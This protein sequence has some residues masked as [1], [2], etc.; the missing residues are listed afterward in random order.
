MGQRIHPVSFDHL[1]NL[2][3]VMGVQLLT[4]KQFGKFEIRDLIGHGAMGAVYLAEQINLNRRPVALKVLTPSN[5][6]EMAAYTQRFRSEAMT[7]ARLEHPNIINIYDYGVEDGI[8]YL[9]MKLLTGGALSHRVSERRNNL[10]SLGEVSKLLTELAG[11]LD[12]AH[13]EDVIHRDV[14]ASNVMFDRH[15]NI[16]LVDFGIARL[17]EEPLF[18]TRT[19]TAMGTPHYMSPEQW[20]GSQIT[21]ATDQYSL[22]IMIYLALTGRLPYESPRLPELMRLHLMGEMPAPQIWRPDLPEA[23]NRALERAVAKRSSD[24]YPTCS[25]F[26]QHFA[27]II[28]GREGNPTGFFNF[29]LQE[30]RIE[31]LNDISNPSRAGGSRSRAIPVS[32]SSGA[33]R[34]PTGSQ[35]KGVIVPSKPQNSRRLIWGSLVVILLLL[36]AVVGI[37]SVLSNS[38]KDSTDNNDGMALFQTATAAAMNLTATQD[39]NRVLSVP[40]E[41]QNAVI[42]VSAPTETPPLPVPTEAQAQ[43]MPT[44]TQTATVPTETQTATVPVLVVVPPTAT[45]TYT[46]TPTLSAIDMEMTVEAMVNARNAADTATAA[47]AQT[48]A[49]LAWTNT[50]TPDLQLTVEAIVVQTSSALNVIATANAVVS[51]TQYAYDLTATAAVWTSTPTVTPIPT[52]IGGGSGRIMFVSDRNGVTWDIYTVNVDGTDERR[53]T[54]NNA[55][56]NFP[57]WSPDGTRIAFVSNRD[58]N[59]ELYVMNADGS[60]QIRLTF[61][62]TIA[63]NHP[64]W[65]YDGKQIFFES[66]QAG[67]L[68]IFVINDMGGSIQMLTS[69]PADDLLP[70]Q[71]FDGQWVGFTSMRDGHNQLY[72]MR[73]NGA[74]QHPLI[75]TASDDA[76][77][78]WYPDSQSVLF[79]S[80]WGT[81]GDYEIFSVKID[82]SD[83]RQITNNGGHNSGAHWSP[84]GKQIAFWA[85]FSG[86]RQCYIIDVEGNQQYVLNENPSNQFYPSW[87]PAVIR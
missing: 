32:S 56:D 36:I 46:M 53:L 7:I 59:N 26:A 61:T 57:A 67:N 10:P 72:I 8:S 6:S 54:D 75:R 40:T 81:T 35:S 19:G 83:V 28:R 24:R 38:D 11:A 85:D 23:A 73:S 65:S 14:K 69:D 51:A 13:R 86:K 58:G 47:S 22:G 27:E 21:Y 39:A 64:S 55:D 18:L 60:N 44:E 42:I 2:G 68:D 1:T 82:G 12:Y 25:T 71:S 62:S 87:Q 33:V 30:H 4:G 80:D 5:P 78:G 20:E 9:A 15:G 49:A 16:Y 79:R 43:T 29:T 34:Q 52:A 31:A 84:D 37:M 70:V 76:T 48:A 77:I 3:A 66:N 50:P 17:G 45:P 41:T 74:E 63:E